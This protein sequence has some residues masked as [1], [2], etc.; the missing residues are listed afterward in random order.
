M[1]THLNELKRR[2]RRRILADGRMQLF[3][4]TYSPSPNITLELELPIR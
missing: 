4:I 3:L 1:F 2:R